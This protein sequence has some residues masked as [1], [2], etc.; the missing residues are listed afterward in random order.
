MVKR[1]INA[2]YDYTED[3]VAIGEVGLDY[4][5]VKDPKK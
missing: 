3:I 5:W 1:T 2:I 4:Y